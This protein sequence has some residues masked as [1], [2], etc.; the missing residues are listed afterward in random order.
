MSV[1]SLEQAPASLNPDGSSQPN[2]PFFLSC[3]YCHW[4][5]LDIGIEFE[6]AS[7]ITGQL[8]AFKNSQKQSSTEE[9]RNNSPREQDGKASDNNNSPIVDQGQKSSALA[10]VAENEETFDNI[11]TFFKTQQPAQSIHDTGVGFDSPSSLAR[12]M[13]LY[14][15]AGAKRMR[16]EKPRVIREAATAKE[17]LQQMDLSTEDRIIDRLATTP[18]E[19]LASIE[20]RKQQIDHFEARFVDELRPIPALLRTRRLKRCRACRNVLYR[21]EAK[22]QSVRPK[23]RLLAMTYIPRISL[24]PFPSRSQESGKSSSFDPEALAPQCPVQFLLT[25]HNPLYEP[26]LVSLATPAVTPGKVANRVT[27]LCPQFE[28]GA[29]TDVWDEALNAPGSGSGSSILTMREKM[30][31]SNNSSSA[32][33]VLAAEAGKI[34]ERGRNWTTVVIEVVPGSRP[35]QV[36]TGIGNDS[37]VNDIV[38]TDTDYS[39]ANERETLCDDDFVLEIPVFVRYEYELD[40]TEEGGSDAR[41]THVSESAFV[42][43]RDKSKGEGNRPK[44]RPKEK[45]DGAFWSVL[46]VGKVRA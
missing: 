2:G 15:N 5:S 14:T 10:G 18:W 38:A 23:I 9:H 28:V 1:Q 45:R 16:R 21:P 8:T 19:N 35:L 17:G 43:P 6:K 44:V 13:N 26:M 25:L 36:Q 27:I 20:Q 7:N 31:A 40:P 22:L 33:A 3:Q 12:I 39:D 41:S 29:S 30:K 4:T 11:Q 37:H 24:S 46:G 42:L 34:W 32:T